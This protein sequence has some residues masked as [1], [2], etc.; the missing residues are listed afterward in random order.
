L[1]VVLAGA[2]CYTKNTPDP[3]ESP[4]PLYAH[5]GGCSQC[6]TIGGEW[7]LLGPELT[8]CGTEECHSLLE[9]PPQQQH[10]AFAIRDCLVCHEP[11]SSPYPHLLSRTE[12]DLC[13]RCHSEL[14]TCPARGDILTMG[15]PPCTSCHGPHGGK[16]RFILRGET[17]PSAD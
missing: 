8:L 6:H 13:T 7:K 2:G 4:T 10:G 11:H 12:P 17:A 15:D 3:V 9:S 5:P 14:L 1:A 16:G